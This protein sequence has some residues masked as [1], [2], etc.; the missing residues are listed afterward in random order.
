MH[1][2]KISLPVNNTCK[3]MDDPANARTIKVLQAYLNG[4]ELGRTPAATTKGSPSKKKT[5]AS[6]APASNVVKAHKTVE[7]RPDSQCGSL[8]LDL[9]D[10]T[11]QNFKGTAHLGCCFCSILLTWRGD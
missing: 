8:G 2:L 1:G 7:L 3:S 6:S 4:V 10:F 11:F 5:L 9:D